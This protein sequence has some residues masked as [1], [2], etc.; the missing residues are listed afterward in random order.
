M[1]FFKNL[2]G[3]T[4]EDNRKEADS[5]F[6]EGRL[7][8]AKLAYERALAKARDAS[9]ADADAVRARIGECRSRLAKAKIAEAERLAAD[10]DLD[11]A[12]ASLAEVREILDTPET[13]AEVEERRKK[14]EAMKARNLLGEID[15]LSEDELIAVL[16]GAWTEGQADE[17]AAMPE[18]FREALLTAHD[19]DHARAAA[20][21]RGVLDA[22]ELEV[23]PRYAWFELGQEL[24]AAGEH[25][26]A[27]EALDQFLGSFEEE[28]EEDESELEVELE[29]K[30]CALKARALA[31]LERFDD[32]KE[33]ILKTTRLAP[34][35]YSVYLN[36]GVFLRGRKEHERSVVALERAIELMGQLR[37]DFRVVRELGFTYAAMGLKQEAIRT[38]AS[39]LEHQASQGEHDQFD[40]EAGVVLAR[41]HEEAGAF[42][43]A[44]DIHRHL[45]TGY[46]TARHFLYNLESARLLGLAK[47]EPAL[48]DRY[49]ARAAEIAEND[50]QRAMVEALRAGKQG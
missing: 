44:A 42:N 11:L 46:D 6:V 33:E 48:V 40:P 28:E 30:A 4:F 36:Y 32:A 2:F 13:R 27:V 16:A 20:L 7:G 1:S 24:V 50:E 23:E 49:L 9:Q 18:P 8:E 29:I 34:T 37:P 22:P 26:K 14:I 12:L 47:A 3:G 15:E 31:A 25:E 41:L 17:Y 19:G 43:D 35:D 21:I 10:G 38:L 5:F 45:A 39:V